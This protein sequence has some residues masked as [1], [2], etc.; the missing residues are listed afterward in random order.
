MTESLPSWSQT[1]IP[2]DVTISR[3]ANAT[4]NAPLVRLWQA[5]LTGR[6]LLAAALV[7]LQVSGIRLQATVT[8]LI[9]TVCLSYLALT[10]VLRWTA[11]RHLPAPRAGLQW[12]PVIG[13]DI[14][15]IF[16][17]QVLQA[18][19]L[20]YTALLA[21]PILISAA[22]GSL[23]LAFGTTASV[24]IL[25]LILV[26]WQSTSAGGSTQAYYQTAFACAG[27]F[28]VAYLTHELARRVRRER[29]LALYNRLRTQTQEQVNTLVIDSLSDGVLVVDPSLQV[30]QANPAALQLLGLPPGRSQ[31]FSLAARPDWE[32]L[33]EAVID[34]FTH[35]KPLS[36]TIH[37]QVDGQQGLTGLHLR[38]RITEVTTPDAASKR[39]PGS[40]YSLC[41]M[42]LH[43]LREMEAQLRTEKLAAMGRMS[44]A[45][46]HEIRNPLAAIAQANALLSEDL[47]QYPGQQQLCRIVGQN[48]DRLARIAEEI[49]NIA[50][51]QQDGQLAMGQALALDHHTA[52]CCS[53]WQAQAAPLRGLQLHLGAA[54][55]AI[56][57]DEEHLR[58]ILVNLLD[59]AQRH[60]SGTQD[61]ASL[62]VI[63]SQGSALTGHQPWLQVWSD[64]A[65]LE[66]SV[67][68]HLFEPFFSSQSRSSGL[69]LYICRELCERYGASIGY[70]RLARPTACGMVE[71]NAFTV[72]FRSSAAAPAAQ[73]AAS[74]FDSIVV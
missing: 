30:Q 74:L 24:T 53:E 10:L 69:G 35:V 22:L 23:P 29:A 61:A 21:I 45:V 17:L 36:T 64:G 41:V 60:R 31:S 8:P 43:D 18:G 38:T 27:Y 48:A 63:T 52:L 4:L 3:Q 46:A 59:N 73:A 19:T 62:Q 33:K 50:R 9:W 54:Q 58:R 66:S 56:A 14:A 55:H 32:P 65:P 34:S 7:L 37:L 25:M 1:V 67:Q 71:G 20:N 26:S 68:R 44:A 42:F 57:F 13:V 15:A 70:Q 16:L 12:L 49:L 6:V 5:F 40:P 72:M 11:G 51:V 39:A 47:N 2:L 28:G